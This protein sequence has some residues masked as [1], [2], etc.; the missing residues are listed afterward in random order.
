M[1]ASCCAVNRVDYIIIRCDD[2][3]GRYML[4]QDYVNTSV[5]SIISICE[6]WIK[7]CFVITVYIC[8]YI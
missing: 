7:N 8:I 1:T 5:L 6:V 4:N 3:F 2:I